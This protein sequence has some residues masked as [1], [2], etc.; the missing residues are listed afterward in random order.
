M[1]KKRPNMNR[2]ALL[3]FF[4]FSVLF[5]MLTYRFFVIQLTGQAEG[6]VLANYAEK[7]YGK[8]RILEGTRG[9]IYDRNGEPLAINTTAYKL[10]AVLDP[11]VTPEN[12]ETPSH[13][14]DPESTAEQ[15]ANYID[16]DEKD[17][18]ARL[19]LASEGYFQVEFGN[20]G[21]NLSYETK[22]EIEKLNLPGI[23]FI[24]ETKRAYPNGVFASHLIGFAQTSTEDEEEQLIGQIGLEKALNDYLEGK[25]GKIEY[26][27][28]R[29]GFILPNADAQ[30]TPPENGDT[31]YL[32]LDKKIQTFLENA[33][34]E[35]NEAYEPEKMMGIVA[36]AKT[37][38]ILAMSQRP[39]FDPNTREGID[40]NWQNIVVETAFE[41]GSTMKVFTLAAAIEEGVFNPNETYMSGSFS[42][43]GSKSIR[44]HNYSGWGEITFLEGIQ[45]SSNVAVSYLVEKMGT[46]VFK[47]YLDLFQFGQ[48]TEIGLANEASGTIQYQWERDKYATSYGQASSVTALQ[49]VQAMTAITNDGK[50]MHPYLVEKIVDDEGNIVKNSDEQ[51]VATPISAQTAE[52]VR[53]ILE[54]VVTEEGATG[55]RFQIDGYQ[56]GGKTGTAQIYEPGV[57]YLT[58]WDNYI[59]SFIGFAPVDD[60]QLIVYVMVQQPDLDEEIYE[61]G[62]VPVSMVFNSVMKKSLQYLNI[63]P[64]EEVVSANVNDMPDLSGESVENSVDLLNDMELEPV[65]IGNG[66]NVMSFYPEAGTSLLEGEK[67]MIVTD[68]TWTMPDLTGW[69]LRDVL[70]FSSVTGIQ[71]SYNGNGYVIAQSLETDAVIS[72]ENRLDIELEDPLDAL[73]NEYENSSLPSDESDGG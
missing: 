43:E 12:A 50:M 15:L 30:I 3:L 38:A 22:E 61:A 41:P 8:T 66:S 46:D 24:R 72:E 13:V 45:K 42:V 59:F 32:T 70:K 19:Q 56:V 47:N 53:E 16:M 62:S 5:F 64:D 40:D 28:D 17:I 25:N 29:W 54:T 67:V 58:G 35:V 2:R 18:L 6:Q 55:N 63:E 44:D 20:A 69:S 48:P 52:Q 10:V 9:S 34:N 27:S 26:K 57:G 31:V 4:I 21:R 14:V 65:V 37:G 49:L 39:T 60:P 73:K 68:G 11:S 33:M 1:N 23:I 51:Q 71:I 36:D 7:K